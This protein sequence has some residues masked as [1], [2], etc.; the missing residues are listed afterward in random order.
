MPPRGKRVDGDPTTA[1]STLGKGSSADLFNPVNDRRISELIVD[2][3]RLLI[4][5]QQLNPGDRLPAE[6]ELCERFGVS[7]VTVREALRVLEAN[8]LVEIRVGARGGAFVTKPSRERLGEGIADLLTLSAVTAAE[9]T[10]VRLILELGMIPLVCE[11]ADDEDIAELL[12]ICDRQEK[13][14]ADGDY[15]MNLSAEFHSRLAECAHNSAVHMLTQ[16]FRGPLLMSLERAQQSAPEMGQLGAKE[17]R[18]LVHAI[19]LRDVEQAGEIMRQ[20]LDR[21]ARRVKDL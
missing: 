5:Q 15:H 13:A 7:R 14:L 3:V 8:G 20:H 11:R 1:K 6:R 16:S 12:D 10:E 17:H 2:Q 19:Q 18:R 21:T 4:R 9:V